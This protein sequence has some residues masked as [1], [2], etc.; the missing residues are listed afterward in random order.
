MDFEALEGD[1]RSAV[2][3]IATLRGRGIYDAELLD[4][5]AELNGAAGRGVIRE[6]PLRALVE[7]MVLADDVRLR[8]GALLVGRGYEVTPG[9]LERARN[10]GLGAV[11]EP[12]RVLERSVSAPRPRSARP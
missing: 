11:A 5:L 10:F 7:G 8:N 9:F 4:T 1:G 3:A 6:V 12:I 2:E